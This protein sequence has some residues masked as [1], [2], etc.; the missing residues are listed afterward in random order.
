MCQTRE[1]Y[2]SFVGAASSAKFKI[3]CIAV[4]FGQTALP[5][6]LYPVYHWLLVID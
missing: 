3:S 6:F 2:S 5:S 4:V 1:L